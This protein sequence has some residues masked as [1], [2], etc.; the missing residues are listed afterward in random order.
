M[1]ETELGHCGAE[2]IQPQAM[3]PSSKIKRKARHRLGPICESDW[4]LVDQHRPLVLQ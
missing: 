2:A 1:S 3:L 4:F